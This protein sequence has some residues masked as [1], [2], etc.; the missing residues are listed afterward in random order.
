MHDEVEDTSQPQ[1]QSKFPPDLEDDPHRAALEDNPAE[2]APLTLS[3]ILA[4]LV[5]GALS[6]LRQSLR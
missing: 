1:G 4:V 6:C 2:S 5:S 3:T